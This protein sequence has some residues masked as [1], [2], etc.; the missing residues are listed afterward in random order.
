MMRATE[1]T[2]GTVILHNSTPLTIISLTPQKHLLF[3]VLW[4]IEARDEAG[5]VRE[6]ACKGGVE[7]EVVK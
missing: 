2:V 1:L 6:I 5:R 3:G 7:W 4:L